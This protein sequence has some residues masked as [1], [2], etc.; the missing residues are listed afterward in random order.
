MFVT[1]S[2]AAE[3]Y[4]KASMKWYGARA[5]SVASSM[6]NKL[7]KRGDLP[8]VRAWQQVSHQIASNLTKVAM[9]SGTDAFGKSMR[10]QCTVTFASS[11]A[12]SIGSSGVALKK[13]AS[14]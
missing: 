4:A 7:N 3:I 9:I 5:R 11:V 2:E 10:D 8:G 1:E 13:V 6:V 12:S 14:V